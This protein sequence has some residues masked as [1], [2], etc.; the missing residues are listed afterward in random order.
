M[1]TTKP[2]HIT[3][4]GAYEHVLNDLAPA[5]GRD[6]GI[7]VQ[8]AVA[9]AAGVIKRLEGREPVDVVL[10]SAAG[11]AQ[12]IAAGLA[13][14]STQAEIGRVRLGV[15]TRPD[16]PLP[17]LSSAAAAREALTST[18]RVAFIDP[19]G[20]GTSGPFIAKLFER[21]G[22]SD[23]MNQSGVLSKTG[24]D[25]VRAVASGEA[26]LGL[27]QAT[28]LIGATGVTFAGYLAPEV[29][30][31]SVYAGAVSTFAHAPD[32]ARR[33]I[34]FLRSPAATERFADAGWDA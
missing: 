5:F 14:A 2:L 4:A 23:A 19:K 9:N 1:S 20:G 26:S 25:V 15:A 18:A 6:A 33:F 10:T 3:A 11:I 13:D 12:L 7:E 29:Q 31:V 34:A 28:E 22:I 27:T 21:L 32:L 17:D 24:K 8:L 16:L 30:V